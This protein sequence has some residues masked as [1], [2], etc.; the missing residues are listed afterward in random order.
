M[1]DPTLTFG[2]ANTFAVA[3]FAFTVYEFANT[4]ALV[5]FGIASSLIGRTVTETLIKLLTFEQK[6]VVTLMVFALPELD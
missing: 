1:I 3:E 4:L 2:K 6:R 5:T